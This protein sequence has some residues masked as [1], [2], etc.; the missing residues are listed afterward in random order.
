MCLKFSMSKNILFQRK[1]RAEPSSYPHAHLMQ[2]YKRSIPF[3]FSY[4]DRQHLLDLYKCSHKSRASVSPV[5]NKVMNLQTTVIFQ[6]HKAQLTTDWCTTNA[7][8]FYYRCPE[9]RPPSRE[10]RAASTE[11]RAPSPEE[12]SRDVRADVG[13]VCDKASVLGA[14]LINRNSPCKKYKDF[15]FSAFRRLS[16]Y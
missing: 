13:F 6:K 14:V 16:S 7:V 2:N 4:Y 5:L 9:S 8:R 10:P 1:M 15:S 11:P 3:T 12:L